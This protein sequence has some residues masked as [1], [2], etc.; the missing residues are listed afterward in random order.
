MPA[1]LFTRKEV[2]HIFGVKPI[3]LWHWEKRNIIKPVMY[4]S[5]RP[6]YSI[7]DIE[8]VGTEKQK[9]VTV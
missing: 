2:A 1:E 8:K 5:G 9:P 7:E 3:T 4:V 6:R